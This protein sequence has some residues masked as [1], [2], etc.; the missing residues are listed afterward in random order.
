MKLSWVLADSASFDP[1]VD[2]EKLKDIGPFWGSWQTWRSCTTDNVI[3]HEFDRAQS[4]V[5]RQFHKGCHFYIPNNNYV[6]LDRPEGVKLY[7]GSFIDIE[8]EHKEEIIALHLAASQSDIVLLKGFNWTEQPL[9]TDKLINHRNH[10]YKHL[11]KHAIQMND[12]I[13]WVLVDH[14]G[15]LFD[16]IKNLPNLTQDTLA[17][18]INLLGS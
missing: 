4:L 12:K 17:N 5:Q 2:I 16:E 6:Q 7:D 1:E 11:V 10:N 14:R 13:Q 9:S 8:V 3:C 15:E 18:V